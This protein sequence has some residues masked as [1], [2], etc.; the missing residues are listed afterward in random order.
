MKD[1]FTIGYSCLKVDDFI[2]ILKEYK[3]TSL[4]DVRSKPFSIHHEEFN[5]TNLSKLLKSHS[6]IYRNY[7]DE[8]GARQ[9]DPIYH[10]KGYLD[11][12]LFSKSNVFQEGVRK[13]EAGM[14][15]NYS[16]AFMCAEKD[17]STCHRNIMVAREFYNR[18]HN[19]KNVLSDG[20]YEIQEELEKRLV[21]DYFPNRGQLD[22]FEDKLSWIEM[23]QKSYDLRNKEIGYRMYED[24]RKVKIS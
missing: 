17:P 14:R 1:I 20:S 3:I 7:K 5:Y 8:F 16:F 23:V 2:R 11:F 22:L 12:N 21:E 6:I 9:E 19:I 24:E 4:I 13:I 18:G 15:L 10:H